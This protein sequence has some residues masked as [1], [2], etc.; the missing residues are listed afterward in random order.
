MSKNTT[1][2]LTA[3]E[4]QPLKY[5]KAKLV[6]TDIFEKENPTED[7]FIALFDPQELNILK[8]ALDR[9]NDLSTALQK[10]EDMRKALMNFDWRTQPTIEEIGSRIRLCERAIEE[11]S[12]PIDNANELLELCDCHLGFHP[13]HIE[14]TKSIK[15]D[16]MECKSFFE[17]MIKTLKLQLD[18]IER[19]EPSTKPQ[20][21]RCCAPRHIK[22]K[23]IL[24]RSDEL[25]YPY[26]GDL[27]QI[28][29]DYLS[30]S[31][32]ITAKWDVFNNAVMSG[33]YAQLNTPANARANLC[34]IIHLFDIY[35]CGGLY[36][37]V[38]AN[39]I[40]LK[41]RTNLTQQASNLPETFKK[42]TERIFQQWAKRQYRK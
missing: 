3:A 14:K 10:A 18:F 39:S 5:P 6:D 15:S 36:G 23:V 7:D 2:T 16:L 27:T 28:V 26:A 29:Y 13:K 42:E 24:E 25:T 1:T 17:D 35:V 38:A 12:S 37:H 40:G 41:G 21:K 9:T 8:K 4:I 31:N 20:N 34:Q 32:D 22:P 30:E 11:V 19:G 33:N